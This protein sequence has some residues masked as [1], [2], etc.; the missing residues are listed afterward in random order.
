MSVIVI[1]GIVS[2]VLVAGVLL[3]SMFTI[4]KG[5]TFKHSVDPLPGEAGAEEN[6]DRKE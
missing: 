3:L 2:V 5:Y 1:V 4:S 6:K